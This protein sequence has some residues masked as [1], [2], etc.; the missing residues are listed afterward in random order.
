MKKI[1]LTSC[2]IINNDFKKKFYKLLDKD[3]N[4][5]TKVYRIAKELKKESRIND[6]LWYAILELKNENF[7]NI[8]FEEE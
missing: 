5:V 1:V 8:I 2:G 6:Q 4:T 3:I 7:K